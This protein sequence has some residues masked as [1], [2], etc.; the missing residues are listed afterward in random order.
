MIGV[1][2]L[3]DGCDGLDV[4]HERRREGGVNRE[5]VVCGA[6]GRKMRKA[7]GGSWGRFAV[8]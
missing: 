8:I 6:E 4:S 5:K 2:D 7:L 3:E 1:K